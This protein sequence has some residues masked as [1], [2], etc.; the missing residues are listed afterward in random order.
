MVKVAFFS[1]K[2]YDT[3]FFDVE[4]KAYG[5]DIV[6]FNAALTSDT[7]SLCEGFDVVCAFVN[8]ILDKECIDVL[9]QYHIKTIALRSAGFNHVDISACQAHGITVVRVPAYSPYAVAE[10]TMALLLTLNRKIHKAYQRIREGNF[11]LDGLLGFDLYQ[12]T[13]G[14]IG[15]GTI[16]KR[17]ASICHGFGMAILAYD[18]SPDTSFIKTCPVQF[19]TLPTLLKRSDIISLHCPLTDKNRH[20]IDSKSIQTM[21]DNVVL[22]N[23]GRGGLIDTKALIDG[24]KSKKMSA[25][26]LDV[27]EQEGAVFFEDHSQDIIDDDLLMR[28]TTFP[29]VL[30]TSHQGFFTNE[31]LTHIASITLSNIQQLKEGKPCANEVMAVAND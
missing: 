31:A 12:K 10:H 26:G 5:F 8:D 25:V 3:S 18:P 19:V 16:G 20:M 23:T 28:L 27:Y 2:P 9:A 7:A 1:T 30:I 11:A 24:L 21:K 6:Y 22:L 15:L 17:F 4:N 29:N 13:I 14:I